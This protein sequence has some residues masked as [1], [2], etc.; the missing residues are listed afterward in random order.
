MNKEKKNMT[1]PSLA[2]GKKPLFSRRVRKKEASH[3]IGCHEPK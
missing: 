3:A 2:R 1:S